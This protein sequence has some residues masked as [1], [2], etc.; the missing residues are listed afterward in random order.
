MNSLEYIIA[1]ILDEFNLK[2]EYEKPF[3]FGSLT[4]IPD[5]YL[6]DQHAIVEV[7]GD[8]WHANPAIFDANKTVF[9]TPVHKIWERDERKQAKFLES[10]FKYIILWETKI[11]NSIDEIKKILWTNLFMKKLH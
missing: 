5:F 2:F 11:N 4:Y 1:S 6:P 8:Y 3:T 9:R 10:K 7:Y